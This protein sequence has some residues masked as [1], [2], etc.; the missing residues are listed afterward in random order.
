MKP[1]NSSGFDGKEGR[2]KRRVF[3]IP[4]SCR[5][6]SFYTGTLFDFFLKALTFENRFHCFDFFFGIFAR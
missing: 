5:S 4:V 2:I 1:A 3:I 6:F